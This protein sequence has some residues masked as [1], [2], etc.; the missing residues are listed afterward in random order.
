MRPGVLK[1]ALVV[2]GCAAL[3]VTFAACESTESESAKIEREAAIAREHEPGALKLGAP[4]RSV[5]VSH[6]TLL[7]SGGRGALALRLSSSSARAQANVPVLLEIKGKAGKV[8]YSNQPGGTDPK[9]QRISLLRPHASA[10]WVN[11][12]VLVNQPS[13][14]VKVRVGTGSRVGSHGAPPPLVARKTHVVGRPGASTVS[15]E[16]VNEGSRA[17]REVPV[18]A[19]ALRGGKVVAAGRVLVARLAGRHGASAR[20]QIPLVGDASRA[21]IELTAVPAAS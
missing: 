17:Q 1:R 19:V 4:N 13:T 10:W 5:R 16:L 8:L 21:K 2:V 20:F 7:S 14:G 11:D 18:F 6:T 9:L 12:Q 3:T 15:G